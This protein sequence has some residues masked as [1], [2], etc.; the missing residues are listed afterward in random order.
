MDEVFGFFPPSAEPPSKRPML[1]LLKQARAHG[2]GVV[3]ATQN[4]VDLDYKGLSN[5]GT[6][7]LGRLQTE[8]DKARVIDGLE[9]ASIASGSS[10]DRAHMERILSGLDSR[11][12]LMNNVHDDQPVLFHTRWTLSYLRGPLTR[13]QIAELMR[14]RKT[15]LAAAPGRATRPATVALE[16]EETKPGE[17][18]RPLV[19]PKVDERFVATL[20]KRG[21]LVYRP[22]L[23]GVASLH[24]AN[25]SANVDLWKN[26]ALMAEL[27][28]DDAARAPWEAALV[29]EAGVPELDDQPEAGARFAT[30]PAAAA[31][32]KTHVRWAKMLESHL[33]REHPLQ[34]WRCRE[35][36]EISN[37]G[38]SEGDF[39]VRVRVLL[40]ERRDLEIEKLR[41]RFAPKLARIQQQIRRAEERVDREQSQYQ[42][43]KMQTAVSL[44]ATV[45]GAIFGRKLGSVGNVG[46]ATTTARGAGRTVREHEDI[47][48]AQQGVE[49][50]RE[51]LAELEREF[52]S[53]L[54]DV[55]ANVDDSALEFEEF[56][57]RPKKAD[58]SIERVTLVWTPWR[59]SE[60]GIAKPDFWACATSSPA[61]TVSTRPA[62][63]RG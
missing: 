53:S 45:L 16:R 33:Y 55:R 3:L 32:P 38:E 21:Q 10:F 50:L 24:Y 22:A 11:V 9:G 40:H 51:Q 29:L 62:V 43:Q 54:E 34:L 14:E 49:A 59:V 17:S 46:R 5:A 58:L 63:N 37:P 7:F 4:P 47:A 60:D 39:R 42:Q 12:F 57:I 8:R 44:G 30:L 41:Q 6:W 28:G 25:A 35:F 2:L 13:D 15:S 19:S 1:T 27:R 20:G 26:F 56:A 48:R 18:G 61:P 52:Q 23:L 31:D 36:K